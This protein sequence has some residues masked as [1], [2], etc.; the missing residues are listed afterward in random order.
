MLNPTLC[1][2]VQDGKDWA[3]IIRGNWSK[4]TRQTCDTSLEHIGK[5]S[6]LS[7]YDASLLI[8]MVRYVLWCHQVRHF[9]E[10]D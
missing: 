5:G 2:V 8:A 3:L 4:I 1:E 9:T 10:V 6:E 7:A